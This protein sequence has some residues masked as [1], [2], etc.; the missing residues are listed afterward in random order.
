MPPNAFRCEAFAAGGSTLARHRAP[1]GGAFPDLRRLPAVTFRRSRPA[2]GRRAALLLAAAAGCSR[3]ESHPA[4]SAGIAQAGA[5]RGEVVA[6]ARDV[7]DPGVRPSS[8]AY[9]TAPAADAGSVTGSVILDGPA[10]ADTTIR[11]DPA[12]AR[13]C[14]AP[15]L[16]DRTLEVQR[17]GAGDAVL[18]AVVWL[19]GVAAGK[20]LPAS[21][22]HELV[23]AGCRL[24]PR[25]LAVT[26][27]GTLNIHGVDPIA[28]RLR[29]AR[30]GAGPDAG[31]VLLRTAMSA[32]GQVVP[33]ER[34]LAEAGAVEVRGEA[35]AWLRAWVLVFDQPYFATTGD[36]GAFTLADVPPG[37]YRLVA[38]HERLGRVVQD[39][40]VA[41]GQAAAVT[42]RMRAPGTAAEGTT[43]AGR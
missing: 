4:D 29:F 42:V 36:G 19:E 33:D 17:G 18:G 43:T 20:P 2:V 13:A 39:V 34:V 32:A 7:T 10:P 25:A 14:R 40:T 9:R 11:L 3:G 27:G 15:T 21:G 41:P 22:R 12:L 37:R 1:T 31:R 26:A 5:A 35:P 23:L 8:P 24:A 16:V 30:A 38:W 6:V 28:S